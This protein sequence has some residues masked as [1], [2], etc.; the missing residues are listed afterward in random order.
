MRGREKL[1][2]RANTIWLGISTAWETTRL[3]FKRI[4]LYVRWLFLKEFIHLKLAQMAKYTWAYFYI[5]EISQ[6]YLKCQ[7]YVMVIRLR[8]NGEKD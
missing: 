2:S 1:R 5:F 3:A 6:E 8:D 7:R 4:R